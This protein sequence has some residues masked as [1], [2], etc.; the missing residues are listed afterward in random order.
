MKTTK[1][2][3]HPENY[4]HQCGSKNVIWYAPNE[5]WNELCESWEIICPKC[6]QERADERGINVIFKTEVLEEPELS[7]QLVCPR[8][9]SNKIAPSEDHHSFMDCEHCGMTWAN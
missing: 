4:C 5:L 1:A 2:K 6:F 9:K 3:S 7:K 8:C